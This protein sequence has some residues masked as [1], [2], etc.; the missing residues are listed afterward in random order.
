MKQRENK[1]LEK[2]FVTWMKR[3]WGLLYKVL[4]Q[5]DK[6]NVSINKPFTEKSKPQKSKKHKG[7]SNL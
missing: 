1:R 5:N 7:C 6:N 4:S 2:G 3:R